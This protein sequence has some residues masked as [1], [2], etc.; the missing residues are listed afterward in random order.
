MITELAVERVEFT[1]GQCWH[2]WM[3]EYDVQHIQDDDGGD[4]ERY[5]HDG[6]GTASPYTAD[7]APPCPECGR[8]W[9]GHLVARRLMPVAS[10]D[11]G[12][13]RPA[14]ARGRLDLG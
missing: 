4:W 11:S 13:P 2:H 6:I 8:H 1:C 10:S 12:T 14:S 9:V 3:A 5:A 7:G